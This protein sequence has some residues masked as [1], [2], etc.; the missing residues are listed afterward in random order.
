[1]FRFWLCTKASCDPIHDAMMKSATTRILL[2]Q[3]L[4]EM[5]AN[6]NMVK[7][8]AE[9]MERYDDMEKHMAK[10]VKK[11]V[12]VLQVCLTPIALWSTLYG[13]N[14]HWIESNLYLNIFTKRYSM[15]MSW[16]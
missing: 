1:M 9:K 2:K 4:T 5:V 14:N 10:P 11:T 12:D 3:L 6:T 13:C 7:K 16:I 8:M 15:E